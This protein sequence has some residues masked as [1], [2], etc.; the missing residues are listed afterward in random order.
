V[1]DA[2]HQLGEV[3]R[4]AREAKGV[5]LARVERDTKIRERYLS[6]LERGEY[7]E[8]PGAVY[9][10]GFLR[11]YGAY[12][13]LDPEYL[14][15]LYRIETGAVA[16]ERPARVAPRPLAARRARA[17]VLTPNVVAAAILTVMVGGFIAYLGYEF[18]NFARQPELTIT[19]PVGNVSG[20]TDDTITVR[21]ATAP[22]ARVT[23]R[24]LP[25][26]PT[27]YADEEGN[28]RVTLSLLP[29]SNEFT[30]R[31]RDPVTNR[32]SEDETRVV[33]V[34][35]EAAASPSTAPSG[36]T[37]TAPAADSTV[38]SPITVAGTAAPDAALTLTATL[39]A[40]ATP[41]FSVVDAGGTA[42]ALQPGPPIAPLP[43]TLAADGT[44]AFTGS[45]ALPAGTWDVVVAPD[46]GDEVTSRV[47]VS[48]AEGLTATLRLEGG[49][50]WVEA[51]A[52]GEPVAGVSRTIATAG[53]S[54]QLTATGELRILAGNAG[55]ARLTINGIDLGAMGAPGAVV[56]WRI[57]RSGG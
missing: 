9:T 45:L 50:S 24:G 13:G 31:A 52:D 35:N 6:A 38:E 11:N 41:T 30:L 21:G 4:T 33:V 37:L 57:S 53:K 46:V 3:L 19:D 48:T 5:D 2:V 47:T 8:L 22:N 56:E 55:A 34:V 23:V 39:A 27:V 17:F 43:V 32:D 7:R 25:E 10:K 16:A 20:Y 44:G 49:D 42:V 29:G 28:F 51:D 36:V 54:I 15:D 12:L 1:T 14:I 40:P 26:N 18:V